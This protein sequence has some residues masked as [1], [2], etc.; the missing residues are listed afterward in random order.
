MDAG[1][2]DNFG[3]KTTAQYLH[4]FQNWINTNTSGVV[5]V[6]VRDLPKGVNLAS[7][8]QSIFGKFMAPL[9]GIYGNITKTQD[10][11]NEQ[12]ISY[13]NSEFETNIE[14]VTLQLQQNNESAVSLSWHLTKSEKKH[15][16]EATQDPY[17]QQE[18]N[19]LLGLLK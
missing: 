10:Y 4:T 5:I 13:L 9:G 6:Q 17:F 1:L 7:R 12:L 19:R 2:R 3:L 11:T 15:I 14:L 16:R 18:L 8:S